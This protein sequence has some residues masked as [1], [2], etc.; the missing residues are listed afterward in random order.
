MGNGP[1]RPYVSR[2]QFLR[3]TATVGLLTSAGPF[4]W[5]QLAHADEA[6]VE[7]LHGQFGADAARQATFSWMTPAAVT[8]PFL[9]LG[10]QRVAA[11]TR[12]YDGYPGF[13][14]HVRLDD[15][16]PGTRNPYAVGHGSQVRTPT[17]T[18]TAGPRPGKPFTF[19]A[20]GDQGT[21]YPDPTNIQD[22]DPITR[23]PIGAGTQ[24]PFQGSLNR[25]LA[26]SMNPAFH[27]IVGDTSYANGDQSIWDLWFRGISSMARTVPWMPSIGNHEIEASGTIG[28]FG[29]AEA[30]SWGKLGY[31]AYRTRFDLPL[32]GDKEWEG[33]WY[34]FRYGSVEFI[35]IDNNDVNTEVTEN[36]GY[37]QGRQRS[38]VERSLKAAAADP[39]VDFIV[40][41]MH[42]AAFSSGLH[43]S[44][45]GVR[46]TWF[47]L[48]TRYGVDLVIQGHDHHYE[49]THLMRGADVALAS[50]GDYVS[51][52]GTMYVVA[53]N[54]GGI[55]RGE[56]LSSSAFTAKIAP[57]QVGT[58]RVDVI[59]DT[60]RGTKRLVLGEY[61]A[62]TGRP[63]R[64]GSSSSASARRGS[65][66]PLLPL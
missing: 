48:F 29:V 19:T 65:L 13:F 5:Q 36:I 8:A 49:R 30:D 62:L 27:A 26:R 42:Q 23:L 14:H 64:K 4:F 33:C 41:L 47:P 51:D 56:G 35:S 58:L 15:L 1:A 9:Q 44:D 53:G 20:F 50:P 43:G 46:K 45:A 16:L 66:P 39:S 12:Q 24:P 21:D 54:G 3:R 60:G 28:G 61:D 59:P 38:F 25:E 2:R 22:V 34:R 17:H 18:W 32:N 57:Q 31:D 37:S 52:I 6:P 7:Q 40:I 63:S 55:Q 11:N 10:G